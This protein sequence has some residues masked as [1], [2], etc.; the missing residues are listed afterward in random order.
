MVIITTTQFPLQKNQLS[1]IIT[2]EI[3]KYHINMFLL[4]KS[5]FT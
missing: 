1:Q 4:L 2:L 3:L 5:W